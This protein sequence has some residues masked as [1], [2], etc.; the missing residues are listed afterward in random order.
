MP[1]QPQPSIKD[2]VQKAVADAKRLAN[3]QMALAKA[4]LGESGQKAGIGAGLGIATLG[5]AIFAILFLLVTLAL[6]IVQ[7]GLQPWAGF[8]IVAVL[9]IITGAITGLLA[10][11]QF[12]EAKPPSL[13]LAEFEKTKAALSGS[14]VAASTV[15]DPVSAVDPST[16][17]GA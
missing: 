5:I 14:P 7:L 17:A 4:E 13:A 2:L 10:R 1:P 3:A 12:T 8:L 6:V 9:L 15:V 11:K 16:I